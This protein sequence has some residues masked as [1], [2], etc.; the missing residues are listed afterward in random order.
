MQ[1]IKGTHAT[2]RRLAVIAGASLCLGSL[3][4][5]LMSGAASAQGIGAAPAQRVGAASAQSAGS[6]AA[7]WGHGQLTPVTVNLE[8]PVAE[9]GT[10]NSTYYALLTNG[11]VWA[12]GYGTHGQLGNGTTGNSFTPVLV[13]FPAG[14]TIKSIPTNSDPW[15]TAYAIDSSGNVWGWGANAGGELCT[16]DQQSHSTPVEITSLPAPVTAVGGADQHTSYDANG[17]VYSCGIGSDGDLGNGNTKTSRVPVKVQGLT[18]SSAVTSIV[19]GFN[20]VGV[21]YADGNY[22]DWGLDSKGQLGNGTVGVNSDVAIQVN[23]PAPVTQAAQ[24]GNGP[25]DGQT[26]VMLSDGSVY[27]WGA[28]ASGQLGTGTLVYKSSPVKISPPAGV[29]YQSLAASGVTSFAISTTGDVYGWGGNQAGE[30]GNGTKTSSKTPLK[31][32]SGASTNT[33]PSQISATSTD[34]TVTLAG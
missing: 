34:V 28:G 14:V 22:Y 20:N 19:S 25:S 16:G 32:L 33:N 23:L 15:D 6:T 2:V 8:A 9:V 27:A 1:V 31:I 26:L 5:L 3:P 24:G 10:S 18:D 21:L 30:L 12:W 17:T 29:T 13:K 7:R 4:A 11:T